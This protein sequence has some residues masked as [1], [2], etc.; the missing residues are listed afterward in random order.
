MTLFIVKT[1][2]IK[3]KLKITPNKATLKVPMD[4]DLNDVKR[5]TDFSK[6]IIQNIPSIQTTLIGRFRNLYNTWIVQ[7]HN[8][9]RSYYTEFFKE[10]K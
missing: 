9:S 8:D 5:L 3:P 10:I 7:L 2:V 4:V 6:Y 1:N